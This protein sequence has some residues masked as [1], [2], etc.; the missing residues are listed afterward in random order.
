MINVSGR[1]Y[2]V[3]PTKIKCICVCDGVYSLREMYVYNTFNTE[4]D[5]LRYPKKIL[6]LC[7]CCK[8][9]VHFIKANRTDICQYVFERILIF[10]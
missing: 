4:S 2:L 5:C 7:V 1:F 8:L 9:I 10:G 3:K 6:H